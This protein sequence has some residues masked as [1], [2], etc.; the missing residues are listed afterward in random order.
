MLILNYKMSA[1]KCLAP[2]LTSL[3]LNVVNVMF[4]DHQHMGHFKICN[5]KWDFK[6]EAEGIK[7]E[8]CIPSML[9]YHLEAGGLNILP[10]ISFWFL[11][12]ENNTGL[13]H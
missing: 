9:I 6:A 13:E 3:T 2:G 12:K 5:C 4:C 8:L 7:I 10:N 1:I 11:N